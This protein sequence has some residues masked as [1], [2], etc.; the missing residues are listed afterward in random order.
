MIRHSRA[1]LCALPPHPRAVWR[2][3]QELS[4]DEKP[5]LQFEMCASVLLGDSK[6]EPAKR[7]RRLYDV[8][9]VLLA[10]KLIDRGPGHSHRLPTYKWLGLESVGTYFNRV[11]SGAC[12]SPHSL[13]HPLPHPLQPHSCK[14]PASPWL[15]R[16]GPHG[17]CGPRQRRG[18]TWVA[19]L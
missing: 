18:K 5:E 3:E 17:M 12:A 14:R 16:L 6:K 15:G 4:G 2:L 7:S 10:I 9:N 11:A 13:P 19:L 8:V 1:A